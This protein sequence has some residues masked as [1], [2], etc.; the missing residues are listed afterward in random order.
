MALYLS[1]G[2]FSKILEQQIN[3]KHSNNSYTSQKDWN[4]LLAA[5]W[6][7]PWESSSNIP[8]VYEALI[9]VKAQTILKES[10]H[11]LAP[12]TNIQMRYYWQC[13]YIRFGFLIV[14]KTNYPLLVFPFS[15]WLL[16]DTF[17]EIITKINTSLKTWVK[18]RIRSKRKNVSRSEAWKDSLITTAS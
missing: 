2:I 3:N 8:L 6:N 4:A 15:N 10:S 14:N 18:E 12:I 11:T 1:S 13:L 17:I 9:V 5:K 16:L 7:D